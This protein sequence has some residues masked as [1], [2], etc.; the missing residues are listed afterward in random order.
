MAYGKKYRGYF[1]TEMGYTREIAIYE[2]GYTGNVVTIRA[3]NEPNLEWSGSGK[4]VAGVV[5]LLCTFQFLHTSTFNV[6]TLFNAN[7]RHY[8]AEVI[9][10]GTV[11]FSGWLQ[12]DLAK[13][14]YAAEDRT[15]IFE[16][17]A[18]DGL[19][20]LADI[21]FKAPD[22]SIYK[23]RESVRAFLQYA[24]NLTGLGLNTVTSVPLFDSYMSNSANA[25]NQV[26]IDPKAFIEDEKTVSVREVLERI[27]Q[28][29]YAWAY[30]R[31]GKWHFVCIDAFKSATP[32]A[33]EY[34]PNGNQVFDTTVY[35][36]RR[37]INSD[38]TFK[39]VG[40]SVPIRTQSQLNNSIVWV[41]EPAQKTKTRP[42]KRLEVAYDYGRMKSQING[43]FF[44]GDT[45]GWVF[46]G[47]I[48]YALVQG[49]DSIGSYM[50]RIRGAAK[51]DDFSSI[52]APTALKTPDHLTTSSAF[53][54]DE[55]YASTYFEIKKS[56]SVKLEFEYLATEH[57]DV[58]I[59]V[60]FTYKDYKGTEKTTS[61]LYDDLSTIDYD[62]LGSDGKWYGA[63]KVKGGRQVR[64][65]LVKNVATNASG[66]AVI[67]QNW[68]TYSIESADGAPAD[69]WVKVYFFRGCNFNNQNNNAELFIR[70]IS[71]G[72][73]DS[74][75][76]NSTTVVLDN[77]DTE[78][79]DQKAQI[80]I[81]FGE[82]V[83]TLNYSYLSKLNGDKTT[84]NWQSSGI[85]PPSNIQAMMGAMYLRQ[86]S[87]YCMVLEGRLRGDTLQ[88]GDSFT[89]NGFGSTVFVVTGIEGGL[90]TDTYSVTLMEVVTSDFEPTYYYKTG[91]KLKQFF[92]SML[93]FGGAILKGFLEGNKGDKD[94]NARQGV[95]DS[96]GGEE[97]TNSISNNEVYK[98]RYELNSPFNVLSIPIGSYKVDLP[99][100]NGV[101]NAPTNLPSSG[102]FLVHEGDDNKVIRYVSNE[103]STFSGITSRTAELVIVEDVAETW[104]Y[105]VSDEDTYSSGEVAIASKYDKGKVT[106]LG[107]KTLRAE[108]LKQNAYL[109]EGVTAAPFDVVALGIG[110]HRQD[111]NNWTG[112][113]NPPNLYHKGHFEV[114]E[115]GENTKEIRYIADQSVTID[116]N[117]Y[118]SGSLLVVDGTI[119]GWTYYVEGSTDDYNMV[120]VPSNYV[121]GKAVDLGRKVYTAEYLKEAATL[122]RGTKT[123][124]INFNKLIENGLY[125]IKNVGGF[126]ANGSTFY[127]PTTD[128]EGKFEVKSN[129]CDVI[130]IYWP[131]SANNDGLLLREKTN[132]V[133]GE[134]F[135]ATSGVV[136]KDGKIRI[137]VKYLRGYG[138]GNDYVDIYD[139]DHIDQ[140]ANYTAG[141]GIAISPENVISYTGT[142]TPIIS[143]TGIYYNPTTGAI[144]SLITQYTDTMARAAFS[145]GTAISISSTGVISYTGSTFSLSAIAPLY[146]SGVTGELTFSGTTSNV[147][148]GSRPYYADWRV[149]AFADTKYVPLTRSLTVAGT[150]G[151]ITISGG[152]QTLAANRTW[153]ADL[154]AIH[155]GLTAGSGTQVAVPT[156]DIYGRVTALTATN[157][158]FPVTSVNGL[159]GAVVLTTTNIAE[160]TNLYWTNARGDARYPLL[161]GSY[162]NPSWITSLAYSKIT[163]LPTTASGYGITDVYT[164]T[165]SD[166]RFVGL[167]GSY[168]NPSFITSLAYSKITGVPDFAGTYV[169]L[170]RSITL[171][172]SARISISANAQTLAADRTWNFDLNTIHAGLS[173]GNSITTP[174]INVDAYGRVTSLIYSTILFPVTSVNGQSGAV[175][176]TTT[177][178]PEGTNLYW[179]NAR[180]DARYSLLGHTH[181]WNDITGKPDLAGTYAPLTRS[182]TVAG[183]IN[184]IVVTGGAQTLGADRTWTVNLAALHLSPLTGGS[185]TQVP[186]ITTDIYG[187]V[188]GITNANI[189]FPA[190]TD[191][192]VPSWV[193]AITATQISNW[194]SSFSWGNH[195]LVGYL[196]SLPAHNHD[197][198]YP[199]LAGS[200][201]NPAWIT[202]LA[203]SKITGAPDFLTS[204]IETDPTVPLHVKSITSSDILAWNAKLSGGGTTNY[205]AKFGSANVLANSQIFDNGSGVGIGTND[206]VGYRFRVNGAIY[207]DGDG[208]GVGLYLPSGR[209][210]RAQGSMFIDAGSSSSI[211]YRSNG[212]ASYIME[213]NSNGSLRFNTYYSSSQWAGTAATILGTDAG[214]NVI[215]I[216]TDR[217]APLVHNHHG[218]YYTKTQ[219]D[220]RY[221]QGLPSHGHSIGEITGL[222]SALDN[223]PTWGD[224]YTR[225]QLN[226]SGAGGVVHWN[227]LTGVPSLSYAG[228]THSISE[229]SG[230][231]GALDGKTPW[232][233][234]HDGYH[235]RLGSGDNVTGYHNFQN[236]FSVFGIDSSNRFVVKSSG[237]GTQTIN[238][239]LNVNGDFWCSG[240]VTAFSDKKLKTN[241]VPIANAL[242]KIHTIGGYNFTWNEQSGRNGKIDVGVIAQEIET[243][244]PSI[245]SEINGYKAVDY[246]KIVPLLIEGIKELSSQLKALQK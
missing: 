81:P 127:P 235:M 167:A 94:K 39:L 224:V 230:L 168:A 113:T 154:A 214:G 73:K 93:V 244:C 138:S 172:G 85:T 130:Q 89:M 26:Q 185:T 31:K 88:M 97:I 148:E 116:C 103:T 217:Y 169:P 162:A 142:T 137:P 170:T 121:D 179:T 56:E 11:L 35:T 206:P 183:T 45:T 209:A 203:W 6:E 42:I 211:V 246:G 218:D 83:N 215:T 65:L 67:K 50:L 47:S 178:I 84:E 132:D 119:G 71:F 48:D 216:S 57:T 240:N 4:K 243:I 34:L 43:N 173:G 54:Y 153:T 188:T 114:F 242:D 122:S 190:E 28:T 70:N 78:F 165:E 199:L 15:R 59:A 105:Y 205:V 51:K 232:G 198:R 237:A 106:E 90:K 143:G 102:H 139:A 222:Q 225:T 141:T 151:K 77:P 7:P 118:R 204:Y 25:I 29:F 195:A 241:I 194:N 196:T 171:N 62:G 193:K 158:S 68:E 61:N 166:G 161:S 213:L 86:H 9:D 238:N 245:I 174:A 186:Q 223:R 110:S 177:N 160:G 69:G 13:D 109:N 210:I 191:P 140:V 152:E 44:G 159:T 234:N 208:A 221:L 18:T 92:G 1:I 184:N 38:G 164:K 155:A 8:K 99:N 49:D 231:Q 22:G 239:S 107:Y 76:V 187:R 192:T 52:V 10:G 219:S 233:H 228:H 95:V 100:W 128:S 14:I 149:E 74:D 82:P 53:G 124:A 181:A 229:V 131:N 117:S 111:A 134:W 104:S 30:Q 24:F 135:T 157:I 125:K 197:D 176:L 147:P 236:G 202:S 129:G 220:A 126:A 75:A 108:Y 98:N 180:G 23:D 20:D 123:G 64:H 226:T 32:T 133:W 80:S 136:R 16:I 115:A 41:E 182:L 207:T 146:Y 72:S 2:N 87:K 112:V 37:L 21:D 79:G 3:Y 36:N 163:G 96:V 201:A 27:C 227:N 200:Y 12:S 60:V 156:V 63:E 5:G 189:A 145:A 46:G 175:S 19:G 212:G 120:N 150:S 33:Y 17:S 91:I 101:E 66:D 58:K 55:K 144:N 40:Q